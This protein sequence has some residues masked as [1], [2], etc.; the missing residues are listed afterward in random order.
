MRKPSLLL[1]LPMITG[2]LSGCYYMDSDNGPG[3]L[4][5]GKPIKSAW[6]TTENFTGLRG[7]GP[8]NIVFQ[9]G[10]SYQIKAE[11]DADTLAKLRFLVKNGKIVI[12]RKSGLGRSSGDPA[13]ITVSAPALSTIS[14][15]GSGDITA[16]KLSGKEAKLSL[17]GSG[18]A[19]VGAVTAETLDA[20]T[21]GSGKLKVAGTVNSAKYSIAGAGALEADKLISKTAK[22]SI[23]GSGN[24]SLYATETVAAR[25]AGSGYIKVTGGAKCTK[26]VAGSGTLDCS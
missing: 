12:G 21:A 25:I 16:D 13:T 8:D 18:S 24:A 6:T 5:N 11:G 17:A 2:L 10:D 1:L 23:A 14:L 4:A 9:T 26:S 20:S 19:N 15:A 22:I 7:S 3:E